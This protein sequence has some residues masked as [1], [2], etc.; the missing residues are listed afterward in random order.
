[1]CSYVPI[2]FK[3]INL[4][5]EWGSLQPVLLQ[6]P[7]NHQKLSSGVLFF[8]IK[9]HSGRFCP[10]FE[11]YGGEGTE[12]LNDGTFKNVNGSHIE[13]LKVG[14]VSVFPF[15]KTNSNQNR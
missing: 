9:L 14:L 15:N 13:L 4:Y 1:M 11:Q 6:K 5:V 7:I 2:A 3:Q 12:F 10:S 8:T